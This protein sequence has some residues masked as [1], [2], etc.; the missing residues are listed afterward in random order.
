MSQS[1]CTGLV[2]GLFEFALEEANDV[3]RVKRADMAFPKLVAP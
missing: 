1:A 2:P 3:V